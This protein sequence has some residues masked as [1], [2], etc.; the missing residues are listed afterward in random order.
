[1]QKA[2]KVDETTCNRLA[3]NTMS[4]SKSKITIRKIMMMTNAIFFLHFVVRG[5]GRK[6]EGGV[7][8]EDARDITK[9]A[10]PRMNTACKMEYC[11]Q[12]EQRRRPR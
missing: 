6:C 7:E 10:Y 1:M 8:H 5:G 2:M 12:N 9:G 3:M 4:D 11:A